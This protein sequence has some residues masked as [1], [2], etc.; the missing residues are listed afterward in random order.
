MDVELSV[1]EQLFTQLMF[2]PLLLKT[3]DQFFKVDTFTMAEFYQGFYASL[4][5]PI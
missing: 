3:L 4:K 5:L 1:H 2:P